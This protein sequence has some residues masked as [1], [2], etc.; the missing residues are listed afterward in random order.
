MSGT[1]VYSQVYNMMYEPDAFI[2]KVIRMSGWFDYFEDETTGNVY[3]SCVIPDATACCAQGV[4]FVWAGEHA[5]P[6]DY[7]PAGTGLTVTGR[8][9]TYREDEYLFMR[10]AD[11]EVEWDEPAS[12]PPS[13]S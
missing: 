2:G 4:E 7:P 1:V 5:F 8:F 11:A 6:D 3:F 9:E 12:I 10:L 13:A